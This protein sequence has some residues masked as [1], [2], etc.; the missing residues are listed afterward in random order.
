LKEK[1]KLRVNRIKRKQLAINS[2][3]LL[4]C[5]KIRKRLII[6]LI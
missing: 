6:N 1:I 5:L 4:R 2:L 3:L